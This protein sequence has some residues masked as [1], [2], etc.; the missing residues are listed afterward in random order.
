[1]GGMPHDSILFCEEITMIDHDFLTDGPAGPRLSKGV[2]D[3][4]VRAVRRALGDVVPE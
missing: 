4:V 2:V 1:M 3:E